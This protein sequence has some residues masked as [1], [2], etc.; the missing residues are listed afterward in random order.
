MIAVDTS[1]IVAIIQKEADESRLRAALFTMPRAVISTASLLELQFVMAGKRSL[2]SWPD[3]EALLL[4]YGIAARPF[5][6]R[7]LQIAREAALRF[8]RGR[9]KAKLNFGDCFAYAL[10]RA[11]GIPLLCT[12]TDFAETDIA[13]A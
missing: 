1:A 3:V 11:E 5:D 7:Q 10:A 4:D 8:G 2:S 13:I 9:H 12:G 6:D